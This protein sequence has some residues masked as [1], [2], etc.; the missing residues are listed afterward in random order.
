MTVTGACKRAGIS[1]ATA[2]LWKEKDK[3]FS[4]RWDFAIKAGTDTLEDA[5]KRRATEGVMEDV[6]HQG[7]VVGQRVK[8]S[9]TLLM[10][11]LKARDPDRFA[12]KREQEAATTLVIDINTSHKP[13]T[14]EGECTTSDYKEK[15]EG[16]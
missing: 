15:E 5:A 8:Y 2:Y 12:D 1:R 9:D 14:I 7:E 11:L 10:F 13:K 4:G 6:Y 16:Q 3:R